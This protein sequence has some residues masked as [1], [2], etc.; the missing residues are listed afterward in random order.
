MACPGKWQHGLKPE[1]PWRFSFDIYVDPYPYPT[2]H[3]AMNFK[4]GP[5]G[6]HHLGGDSC[7][8]ITFEV[9]PDVNSWPF[10][11]QALGF[12]V[13]CVC[14]CAGAVTCARVV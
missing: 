14:V 10:E 12:A 6:G 11:I 3:L 7:P 5:F 2:P 4:K 13:L 9:V 8:P 1:V